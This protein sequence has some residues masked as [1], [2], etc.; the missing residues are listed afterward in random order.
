[1]AYLSERMRKRRLFADKNLDNDVFPEISFPVHVQKRSSDVPKHQF[2]IGECEYQINL[3]KKI[4][5]NLNENVLELIWRAHCCNL[6]RTIEHLVRTVSLGRNVINDLPIKVQQS[7]QLQNKRTQ[8]Q[9]EKNEET[10]SMNIVKVARASNN[11][12]PGE[13]PR[14]IFKGIMPPTENTSG[15]RTF[16]QGIQMSPAVVLE[17]RAMTLPGY[18]NK[19]SCDRT[20]DDN[21][22][23]NNSCK[24]KLGFSIESI[25]SR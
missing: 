20:S 17:A 4:F 9:S 15:K 13:K 21:H 3:L 10:T 22:S 8:F 6:E 11:L 23:S 25:L 12:E 7:P 16:S 18:G 2:S 1:M 14:N 24:P 5:P 19:Q